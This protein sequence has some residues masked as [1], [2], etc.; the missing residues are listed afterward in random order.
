METNLKIVGFANQSINGIPVTNKGL[1]IN[2]DG[3][4]ADINAYDDGKLYYMHLDNEDIK[5]LLNMPVSEDSLQSRLIADFPQHNMYRTPTPYPIIEYVP[6]IKS[7]RRR[8]KSRRTSS[9]TSR[10]IPRR[11]SASKRSHSIRIR[12]TRTPTIDGTIY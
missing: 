6:V 11:K 3:N 8:R 5:N 1:H 2:Y 10:R 9:R 12:K 7:H 4:D